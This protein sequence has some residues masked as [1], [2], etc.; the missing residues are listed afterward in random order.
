M[1]HAQRDSRTV[2]R[3]ETRGRRVASDSDVVVVDRGLLSVLA[4]GEDVVP[5]V[6]SLD[7]DAVWRVHAD[8][9][10]GKAEKKKGK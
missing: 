1:L 5:G 10:F 4:I 9:G 7:W 6:S 8:G 3:Q 2:S